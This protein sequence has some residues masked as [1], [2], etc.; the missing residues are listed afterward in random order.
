D[1]LADQ[2]E[3]KELVEPDVGQQMNASIEETIQPEQPAKLDHP[4]KAQRFPEGC[5]RQREYQEQQCQH[6]G[7]ASR[8]LSGV[9]AEMV[10]IPV[11]SEQADRNRAAHEDDEL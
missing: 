8:K 9:C 7:C 5:H 2:S 3:A 4:W 6:A 10:M 1:V 11:P